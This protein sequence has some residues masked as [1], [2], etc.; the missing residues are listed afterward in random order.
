MLHSASYPT[1][2]SNST[3]CYHQIP[4][5]TENYWI[6]NLLG[7]QKTEGGYNSRGKHSEWV[8]VTNSVPQGSVLGPLIFQIYIHI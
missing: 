1:E 3:F 4:H 8:K 7:R 2:M 6:K 5:M